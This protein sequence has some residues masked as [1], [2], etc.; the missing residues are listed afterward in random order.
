MKFLQTFNWEKYDEARKLGKHLSGQ[1]ARADHAAATVSSHETHDTA[2]QIHQMAGNA[3]KRALESAST[4][5]Q[6]KG[7]YPAI[8]H[9]GDMEAHHQNAS[10][11]KAAPPADV[12]HQEAM[13]RVLAKV[14]AY[15]DRVRIADLPPGD[16]AHLVQMHKQG[17]VH[18][19]PEDNGRELT[20]RDEAAAV[21]LAGTKMHLVYRAQ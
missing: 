2:K 8:K 5:S 15:G 21:S 12:H 6:R 10:A 16:R 1:A 18:L 4:P 7:L 11:P 9:H 3:Y 14:P 19:F 20:A 17:M 13:R